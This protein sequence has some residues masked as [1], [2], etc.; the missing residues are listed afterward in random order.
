MTLFDF[1]FDIEAGEDGRWWAMLDL[2]GSLA[3]GGGATPWLALAACLDDVAGT[4]RRRDLLGRII[5]KLEAGA[6]PCRTCGRPIEPPDAEHPCASFNA[7]RRCADRPTS[8][9]EKP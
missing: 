7:C 3:I 8:R 2:S 4:L 6:L 9:D 1:V 5:G